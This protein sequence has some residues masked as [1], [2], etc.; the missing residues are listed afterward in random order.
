[1]EYY[2]G[3]DVG[4]N[5]VGWAVCDENYDL[6]K[7]RKK[8]MWGIRLFESAL[9]AEQRRVKRAN[10]RRQARRRER[11]DLLQ[12]I[13]SEE[14]RKIDPEFFLRLNE[15]RLHK[16]DK[17]TKMKYPLFNDQKYTDIEYYK[18][19]PT[20]FHLRKKLIEE[21]K[22][23]DL[24]LI[25]LALHNILKYRGHFL[26]QGDIGAVKD[27]NQ[28]FNQVFRAFQ[29][30]LFLD[31]DIEEDKK[32][33]I[34]GILK[35]KKKK[36]SEKIKELKKIF[37]LKKD[38]EEEERK[39]N[40]SSLEQFCKFIV[41]AKGNVA[42][43]FSME[44]EKFKEAIF[45]FSDVKY[46]EEIKEE[47]NEE[48]PD[49]VHILDEI[50]LLY[51]WVSLSDILKDQEYIS[52]AK[53][54]L[55]NQHKRDLSDLRETI[56]KYANKKEYNLFF[57]DKKSKE[58]YAAYIGSVKKNGKKYTLSRCSKEV[59]LKKINN[60]FKN[61]EIKNIKEEEKNRIE[62]IQK[63]IEQGEFLP[64]QRSSDN[65]VIPHQINEVELEK[66]LE[67]ASS[68]FP[69]LN[70]K[71]RDGISNIEKIKKL[72][73]FRIPYFIGPLSNRHK[74][75]G[76]NVWIVRREGETGKIYPWNIDKLVDFEKSNEEFIRRMTNKC[77]YLIGEDVIPRNSLLYSKY[78]V[79]NELNNLK[80][81]GKKISKELKQKIYKDLFEK[82]SKV[83]IGMLLKYLKKDLNDL[84]VE[85]LSG[86]DGDFKSSLKS[87]IDF[88]E[89]IFG[90]K[91][92]EIQEQNIEEIIRWI[93]L[94]GEDKKMLK[95]M[96]K[97]SYPQFTEEE[98]KKITAF[99]Y[100]GWGNFSKKFLVDME[101][102][103]KETLENFSIIDALWEN[104]ENLM[105]LLSDKYSFRESIEKTNREKT[106][107]INSIDYDSIVKDLIT[108]PANKRAI[109][110]SIQI[111][112]E[113]KKVM[114]SEPKKIFI[115]MA[116]G[117]EGK[118]RTKSRKQQLQDLYKNFKG[119]LY[120]EL[121]DKIN[122]YEER[123]FNNIKLFLYYTQMGKC[124][125]TGKEI[126]LDKLL[127]NNSEWDKD[128]IFPQS[129]IKDDSLDNLVL[130]CGIENKSKRDRPINPDIQKKMASFWKYLLGYNL[131]SKKKYD[132]LMKT[133]D[134]TEEELAGFINRQL[135]ETRQSTKL[136]SGTI[137]K[138]YKSSELVYVK[139]GLVS[140]FRKDVIN[141]LKSRRVNDYHHAKDAYLSI[142]VG[143]VYR[144]V[145]TDNP[146]Q[147]IKEDK[148]KDYNIKTIFNRDIIE[149]NKNVW[150]NKESREKIRK[151][152]GRDNIFYTE[153]TYCGKGELFNETH[154]NKKGG[155]KIPLKKGLDPQ[156]YGG[157]F[158][159]KTSYFSFIEFEDKKGQKVRTIVGVPI[160]VA[161]M[162]EHK[163]DAFLEY[164][165]SILG[166]C[167][168]KILYPK[169]KKNALI[170]VEGFPLRI[171]GENTKDI[172]FKNS[173]QLHL[174]QDEIELVR[175]IEKHLEK[176]PEYQ[177]N[178]E[179]DK[180]SNEE[181]NA[182]FDSLTKK[183]ET[184]YVLRPAN[185][186]ENLRKHENNFSASHDLLEKAKVINQMLNLLRCDATSTANLSNIGGGEYVGSMKIKKST[187]G[188]SKLV[189]VNQSITG[190]FEQRIE[191]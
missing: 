86:I 178:E 127:S 53:V 121:S 170:L 69:F 56:Y 165:K 44:K 2:V 60:I 154:K 105:Q 37:E 11:I 95:K 47:L 100:K 185:Q 132:R 34:Q 110:Q 167:H 183:M 66:I 129:K 49:K 123:D 160:Y 8:D 4:T 85:D 24:R 130:V 99:R 65:Q 61:L 22:K 168:V 57:N 172:I 189:L 101:G 173:K 91:I 122:K 46:Q 32:F 48:I 19:Y 17:S 81:K 52:F 38:L 152:M 125:Y 146:N 156:K 106:V 126:D 171:R 90:D 25:Y 116:R 72:F 83:K 73:V 35:D 31:I 84:E 40:E 138:I 30:E 59:F 28:L 182:L 107:E 124:M 166:L 139:A 58:S 180:I 87:Y 3:L 62:E 117:E 136:L 169:I 161:N 187:L 135:V 119:N 82:Y 149:R 97:S 76:A 89:K 158:S 133:G 70:Q 94:Y 151:I 175:K 10:R 80:I 157:Y 188:K 54:E 115:E 96:I 12:E 7:F 186:G 150:K 41:G 51:D 88:K 43:L 26:I 5:S 79:L 6:C 29:E 78:M 112:E 74:E 64:L 148:N 42:K 131:I 18:E 141:L 181:L 162:L 14:M 142:V 191:L 103:D 27:F 92:D 15:S 45:S 137:K 174:R 71:D 179:I 145:F 163:E 176:Y 159:P 50:K 63:R 1:M 109:W 111:L 144:T 140:N 36:N 104:N 9:T 67:N 108:S 98:L 68:Y 33:E 39:R 134:F 113:I 55:Y 114:G 21:N 93:T 16:D 164:C 23:H 13:F 120:Q 155:S 153:Y 77:T 118:E 190:L 20:I 75:E 128:H 102:K 177:I 184:I 147:W 143:N